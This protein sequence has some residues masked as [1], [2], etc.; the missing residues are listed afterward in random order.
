MDVTVRWGCSVVRAFI[1]RH[2]F[3]AYTAPKAQCHVA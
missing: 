2:M 3:A 1:G